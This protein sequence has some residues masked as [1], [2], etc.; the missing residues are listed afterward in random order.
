MATHDYVLANQSGSSFRTDL[1]NALA[2]VV[3]NNSS[4]SEPSTKYAYMLWVDSTNNLVKLRNAAN[5]AWIT[6]FTTAGGLDVDAASNFNE[7]VTFTGASYN[8]VWDKS[9]NALEFA[10]NA[11]CTFGDSDL[12]IY[13]DTNY[14]IIE[15]DSSK[16]KPLH[17]KGDPIW[18]YKTG[19]SELM[20][21]MSADGATN[22]YF[23]NDPKAGTTTTGFEILN[24]NLTMGDSHKVICGDSSDLQ[25][26]HTGGS[27]IDN[28]TDFAFNIQNTGNA[29]MTIKT[30]NSYDIDIQTNAEN[31]IV[32]TANGQVALYHDGSYKLYTYANGTISHGILRPNNDNGCILGTGGY[33]WEAVYAY[34]GTIQTSDKNEK[35]TIIESDL[36]LDFVN[37]LKPVSYKWNQDDGKIHYGLVAQDIVEVLATEGKTDKEFGGLDK[38]SEGSIGLNYS[39]LISPLIKAIQ[40]LSTRIEVLEAK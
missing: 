32:C 13:H 27:T 5:N 21:K 33:R 34:N 31:A 29:K 25:I 12:L 39:E 1:N 19:T 16:T 26:Y 8:A 24:G 2:A 17:I 40:Q 3:T 6:L 23:D 20:C 37:Q 9:D 7:D 22:L 38:P 11:K 35:N 14:S 28:T 36:G 4:S 10:D 30:Q 15:T 18:F